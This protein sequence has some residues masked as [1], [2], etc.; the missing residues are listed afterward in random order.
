M[1]EK[2]QEPTPCVRDLGQLTKF[3][4]ICRRQGVSE[5]K[6]GDIA[7]TFGAVPTKPAGPD[8]AEEGEAEGMPSDEELAFFS[9]NGTR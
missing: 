4:R 5:I 9:V 7:V 3:L 8:E 6:F 2:R 1:E